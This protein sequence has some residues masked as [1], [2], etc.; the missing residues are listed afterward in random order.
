MRRRELLEREGYRR[1]PNSK[2]NSTTIAQLLDGKCADSYTVQG[3][4]VSYMDF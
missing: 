4:S 2:V 3:L 1:N